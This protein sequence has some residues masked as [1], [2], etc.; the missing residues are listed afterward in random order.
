[1]A[2]PQK[3]NGF[4]PLANEIVDH[5]VSFPFEGRELSLVMLVI[6]KTY[7]FGKKED[8]IAISQF[9]D[10][11]GIHEKSACRII[12]RMVTARLLNKTKNRYSFNKNWSEWVV[13]ERLPVTARLLNG[14]RSVP[15][16]NRSDSNKRQYTKDNTT[17]D[18]LLASPTAPLNVSHESFDEDMLKIATVS[19]KKGSKALTEPTAVEK[20]ARA[21]M[22]AFYDYNINKQLN[23]ANKTERA[24]AEFMV[25]QIGLDKLLPVIASLAHSN[26]QQYAPII[27]TPYE[28]RMRWAKL[29]AYWKRNNDDKIIRKKFTEPA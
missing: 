4:I 17:K 25:R 10:A 12:K 18:K 6:R 14:N 9:A 11:L 23:F 27:T 5:L 28:L 8:W 19:R 1:M 2:N 16:G 20:D 15:N 3:E 21:L 29:V 7:G 24:A 26:G 22:A 13:T